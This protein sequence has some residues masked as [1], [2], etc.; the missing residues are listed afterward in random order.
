MAFIYFSNPKSLPRRLSDP[1]PHRM[2]FTPTMDVV[3]RRPRRLELPVWEFLQLF[4]VS[5]LPGRYLVLIML[6]LVLMLVLVDVMRRSGIV[7]I[8]NIGVGGRSTGWCRSG[9]VRS[10]SCRCICIVLIRLCGGLVG[11]AAC[12]MGVS[13]KTL[14]AQRLMR[15]VKKYEDVRSVRLV[16]RNGESAASYFHYG[17]C[18]VGLCAR[19]L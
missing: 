15:R 1:Y 11:C 6:M 16:L 7:R 3:P 14:S 17:S 18:S 4:L 9:I 12:V 5:V 10:I 2:A 8:H 13:K 19:W